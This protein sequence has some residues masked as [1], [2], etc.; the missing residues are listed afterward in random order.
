[1]AT[2]LSALAA[3]FFSAPAAVSLP[4]ALPSL[5]SATSAASAPSTLAMATLLS[6][7]TA[8]FFSAAAAFSLPTALPSRSSATSAASPH[9]PACP[10]I[11]DMIPSEVSSPSAFRAATSASLSRA[12]PLCHGRSASPGRI[13][14]SHR[15]PSLL[16]AASSPSALASR[17]RY[18]YCRLQ[19]ILRRVISRQRGPRRAPSAPSAPHLR[20][21]HRQQT[22]QSSTNA[23]FCRRTSGHGLPC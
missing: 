4:T 17:R 18:L 8:R 3:R 22:L 16:G 14:T 15:R 20:F 1:M 10:T 21:C 2:W 6:A 12:Q 23:Q 13:G 11:L 9:A 19:L 7:L 5:S